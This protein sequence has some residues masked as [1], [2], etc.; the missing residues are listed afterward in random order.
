MELQYCVVCTDLKRMSGT[1]V[2]HIQSH[3]QAIWE[4]NSE[5]KN[6]S[7]YTREE[8]KDV[9]QQTWKGQNTCT[10]LVRFGQS[11]YPLA[12]MHYKTKT[13]SLCF[14]K[15]S[16]GPVLEPFSLKTLWYLATLKGNPHSFQT[17]LNTGVRV[18]VRTR[19]PDICFVCLEHH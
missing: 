12:R 5:L 11:E 15:P 3:P 13:A 18:P 16:T 9:V 7:F 19:V 4:C 14:V 8:S 17:A 6:L 2:P 1:R 10:Y